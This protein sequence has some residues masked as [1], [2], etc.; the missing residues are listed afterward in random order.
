M[1]HRILCF[2]F[3]MKHHVF[4]FFLTICNLPNTIHRPTTHSNEPTTP[5]GGTDANLLGT[6]DSQVAGKNYPG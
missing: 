3:T 1:K 2:I 5:R 6:A 4:D